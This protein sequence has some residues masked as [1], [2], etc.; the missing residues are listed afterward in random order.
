[1][2]A[3]LDIDRFDASGV[4]LGELL[5]IIGIDLVGRLRWRISDLTI[6]GEPGDV[7]HA[8]ALLSGV[9]VSGRRLV[10][11]AQSP[12]QVVSGKFRGFETSPVRPLPSDLLGADQQLLEGDAL[13]RSRLGR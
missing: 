11:V 8:E 10:A 5:A 1:M 12:V 6:D 4:G 9:P 2:P 7:A 13:V 3:R